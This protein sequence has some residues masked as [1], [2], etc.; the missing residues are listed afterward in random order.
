[1][2]PAQSRVRWDTHVPYNLC[3]V[4]AG[5]G[6]CQLQALILSFCGAVHPCSSYFPIP[7]TSQT[8]FLWLEFLKESSAGRAALHWHLTSKGCWISSWWERCRRRRTSSIRF[9]SSHL[10]KEP[11]IQ[12]TLDQMPQALRR[13]LSR[14][15]SSD[16]QAYIAKDIRIQEG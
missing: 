8:C 16:M 10:K 13:R 14:V 3:V 7:S 15:G 12:T 1:M 2:S 9:D 5:S 11:G 6:T 4:Q